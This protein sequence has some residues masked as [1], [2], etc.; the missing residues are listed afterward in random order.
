MTLYK[1]IAIIYIIAA[2]TLWNK[3][4][5]EVRNANNITTFKQLLKTH[6]FNNSMLFVRDCDVEL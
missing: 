5:A 3:L 1:F 4:P 6:I 2:P